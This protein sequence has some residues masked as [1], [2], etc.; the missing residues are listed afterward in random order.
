MKE[1]KRPKTDPVPDAAPEEW[2]PYAG[3]NGEQ[4]QEDPETW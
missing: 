3:Q 4:Q 2:E 1:P